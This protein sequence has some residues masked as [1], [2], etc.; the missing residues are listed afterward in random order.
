MAPYP[1]TQADAGVDRLDR[2]GGA[3][4]PPDLG[5]ELQESYDLRLEPALPVPR[6]LDPDR[7]DVRD[8]GLG[9]L[10]VA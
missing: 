8:D 6:D 5:V 2:V 10:P 7:T 1:D 9:P 4:D 3:D